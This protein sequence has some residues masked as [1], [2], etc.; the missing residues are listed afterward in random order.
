MLVDNQNTLKFRVPA[1]YKKEFKIN[2]VVVKS[3][4]NK[5]ERSVKKNEGARHKITLVNKFL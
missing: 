3:A 2:C 1:I 4:A 5:K